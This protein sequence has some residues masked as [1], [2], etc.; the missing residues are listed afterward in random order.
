MDLPRV[1]AGV[2]AFRNSQ[3]TG[4]PTGRPGDSGLV[5]QSD[6][7]PVPDPL[8]SQGDGLPDGAEPGRDGTNGIHD[9]KRVHQ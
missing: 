7:E 6:L 5:P 4:P 1:I 9:G 8:T 3:G 2:E